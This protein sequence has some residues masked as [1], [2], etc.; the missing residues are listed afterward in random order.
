MDELGTFERK[1]IF[2]QKNRNYSK[3]F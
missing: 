1:C 3:R 2:Y